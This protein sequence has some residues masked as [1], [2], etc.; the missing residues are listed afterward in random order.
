[1]PSRARPRAR[2]APTTS[3]ARRGF[4]P[5]I[6]S[7]RGAPPAN[8]APHA[9]DQQRPNPEVINEEIRQ[10]PTHLRVT[11]DKT[12]RSKG[13]TQDAPHRPHP[14]ADRRTPGHRGHRLPGPDGPERT[15]SR[16]ESA[17]PTRAAAQRLGRPS[18][19][20]R[21]RRPRRQEPLRRCREGQLRLS[22]D[23]SREHRGRAR[24]PEYQAVEGLRRRPG[25]GLSA[26]ARRE[27]R[28]R[29]HHRRHHR[30]LL[31]RVGHGDPGRDETRWRFASART[32]PRRGEQTRP[33]RIRRPS[34]THC[35]PSIQTEVSTKK[36]QRT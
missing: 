3:G 33:Q 30:A 23:R 8:R 11:T 22:S 36:F 21:R 19:D 24:R 1:M 26:W 35:S 28:P 9:A 25:P 14:P 34:L 10:R 2:A 6:R 12:I 32:A 29:R 16:C 5:A 13:G 31:G 27:Q 15:G 17:V 4:P 7:P 20:R 18:P